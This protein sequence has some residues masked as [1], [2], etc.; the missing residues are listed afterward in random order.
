LNSG[1]QA[2][3]AG[4][5][6]RHSTAWATSRKKNFWGGDIELWIQGLKLARQV[7]FH[8]SHTSNLLEILFYLAALG[9]ELRASCLLR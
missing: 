6:N 2:Y 5:Q 4:L 7:L 3:K 1:L 8:L 9:F